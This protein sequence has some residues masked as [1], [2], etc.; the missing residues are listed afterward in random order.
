MEEMRESEIII[1]DER[2]K[3]FLEEAKN[4]VVSTRIQLAKIASRSQFKLY[5]WLGESIVRAQSKY[6]WGRSVV[7][8]LAKDLRK[9]FPGTTQGFSARNLWY[10]RNIYLE[11]KD[12]EFLQQ[13][14]AEIPWGQNIVII[15]K[16]KSL[17]ARRYYLEMTR[18][19][20][21]TRSTLI[22]QITSQAYERQVLLPKQHNFSEALPKQL[23][24]QASKTMKDIYM[25]DTLG[26]TQPVL[27]AEIE[28][29]MV[30]KIKT[31]CLN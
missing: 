26:L 29:R 27:E 31:L 25:L 12:L 9:A 30:T 8:Q 15:D 10:M 11:Y 3:N 13:V 14:V 17:E 18:A 20:G 16:V 19:E 1:S 28:N 23:A 6:K 5:W 7:E 4:K 2:Y 24:D 22:Q 21:W